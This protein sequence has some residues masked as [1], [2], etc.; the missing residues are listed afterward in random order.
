MIAAS[1]EVVLMTTAKF[2]INK[3]RMLT[4]DE[5]KG[6]FE[7]VFTEVMDFNHFSLNMLR[8]MERSV[9]L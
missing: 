6:I 8:R 3:F 4:Y 1:M 5:N 7:Q 9:L 2:E